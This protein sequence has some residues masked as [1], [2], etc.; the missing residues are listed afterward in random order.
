MSRG[1]AYAHRGTVAF[2]CEP[3]YVLRGYRLV[4]CRLNSTW[5]LPVPACKRGKSS[6]SALNVNP[7][8]LLDSCNDWSGL[9]FLVAGCS[10]PARLAFAELKEPYSSQTFFP[11]GRTVE[12]V[13]R[14]GY[15]Q[16]L[17]ILPAITCLRNETW[18]VAR[19]FCKST[20]C[21]C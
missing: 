10:A 19:E 7:L 2:E 18:S 16:Q 1:T 9:S 15:I 17:G 12:Y 13:C 21:R 20:S 8:L 11:V 5:A 14:P 3:G 4:Q 6:T